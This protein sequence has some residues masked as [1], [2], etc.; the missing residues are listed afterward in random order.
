MDIRLQDSSSF[1]QV[2]VTQDDIQPPA[3]D[4]LSPELIAYQCHRYSLWDIHRFI[5]QVL[6]TDQ[7]GFLIAPGRHGKATIRQLPLAW[8][9]RLIRSYIHRIPQGAIPSPLIALFQNCCQKMGLIDGFTRPED[10]NGPGVSEADRYNAFLELIRARASTVNKYMEAKKYVSNYDG[11]MFKRLEKYIDG[12]FLIYPKLLVVRL[13]LAYQ[14]E[15]AEYITLAQAKQDI[16]RF[17]GHRRWSKLFKQC[18][19]FIIAR[20]YGK[21]GCGF[22]FHC[23]L[24]FDG[25]ESWQGINLAKGIGKDYWEGNITL[26]S[27]EGEDLITRGKHYNCNAKQDEYR[28]CGIGP[29]PHSDEVKR[30]NLLYSLIYLLKEDQG[31]DGIAPPRT[32]TITRGQLPQAESARVGALRK[33]WVHGKRVTVPRQV[34]CS[35][36]KQGNAN[37]HPSLSCILCRACQV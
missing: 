22:H 11:R 1:D 12:L 20:E 7:P 27:G 34:C 33:I 31:L 16:D 13:D 28:Y 30:S 26:I 36:S 35:F 4:K 6:A 2:V 29:I 15:F 19:G 8:H 9:Y 37:T 18:V 3:D 10:F 5:E 21:N 25:Q 24:F 14:K 17:I 32:R 23:I